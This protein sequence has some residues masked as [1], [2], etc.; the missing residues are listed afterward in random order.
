MFKDK[1]VVD[2]RITSVRLESLTVKAYNP[3]N[4]V[5]VAR[6]KLEAEYGKI[7]RNHGTIEAIVRLNG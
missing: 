7:A 5:H 2:V 6:E 4:A 1:Y 3:T